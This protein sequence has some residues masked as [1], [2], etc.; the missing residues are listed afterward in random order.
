MID[1]ILKRLQNDG[2]LSSL[3]FHD[4]VDEG[5]NEKFPDMAWGSGHVRMALDMMATRGL[6]MVSR[7]D[8][9]KK[10]FDLTERVLP[11][12]V[13]QR[14]PDDVEFGQFFI[15]TALRNLGVA[16][17]N[18]IFD[19]IDTGEKETLKPAL[20]G[21]VEAGTVVPV[22]VGG[23]ALPCFALEEVFA[24]PANPIRILTRGFAFF[25]PST[26]S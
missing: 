23:D 18:D 20:D 8:K 1:P 24:N 21:M 5:R 13:N 15:E 14:M 6:I 26:I 12:G 3:G 4:L 16:T 17:Q 2:P 22:A 25:R 19:Y 7:R 9:F 11:R 10:V